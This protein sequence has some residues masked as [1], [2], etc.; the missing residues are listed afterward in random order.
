MGT[1]GEDAFSLGEMDA[2]LPANESQSKVLVDKIKT[3]LLHYLR[4]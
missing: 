2:A 1:P 3:T 4:F